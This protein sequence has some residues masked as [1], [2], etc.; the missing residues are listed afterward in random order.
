MLGHSWLRSVSTAAGGRARV[1]CNVFRAHCFARHLLAY[2]RLPRAHLPPRRTW[3]ATAKERN[4][5]SSSLTGP[6]RAGKFAEL[7]GDTGGR[8]E[9]ECLAGRPHGQGRYLSPKVCMQRTMAYHNKMSLCLT[10]S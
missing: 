7:L 2:L 5:L 8:Y 3:T 10:C 9:G 4:P 1:G 6:G